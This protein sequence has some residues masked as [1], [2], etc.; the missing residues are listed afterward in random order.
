MGYIYVNVDD[1]WLTHERDEKGKVIVDP[2][3]F[4][5][6]MKAIGDYIHSKGLKYGIYK[7]AGTLTCEGRSGS[8]YHEEL[9]VADFVD[10]GVDFLKYDN[11]FN[12]GVPSLERYTTMRDALSKASR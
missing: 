5:D 2:E 12:E 11:C 6:G 8:L 3:R 7:S 1:C 4:P 10:W 9:D